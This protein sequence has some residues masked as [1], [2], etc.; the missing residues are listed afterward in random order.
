MTKEYFQQ[1]LK[2]NNEFTYEEHTFADLAELLEYNA[3]YSNFKFKDG[4][5]GKANIIGGTNWVILDI[6]HSHITDE[7]AHLLF[8][9]LNHHI[10]RTSDPDNVYK[11]RMLI[12]LDSMV[13][14][15]DIQWKYFIDVI[16][17]ELSIEVDSLPKAQIYYSYAGRNVLSILDEGKLNTKDLITKA[18]KRQEA[19][20]TKARLTTAQATSA[21]EDYFGTFQ[22]AF[23]ADYGTG[24]RNLVRAG[25]HAIDLGGNWEYVEDLMHRISDYWESPFPEDRMQ[26]TVLKYLRT[27]YDNK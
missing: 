21:L 25:L 15:T 2:Q 24:S 7:E 19:K 3:I 9:D 5:R 10:V 18:A 22:Y 12:E 14:I 26:N 1:V 16:A 4:K 13:D 23:E 11:F 6:D 20:P 17:D 8:S 27:R